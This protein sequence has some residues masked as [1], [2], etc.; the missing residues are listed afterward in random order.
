M[1]VATVPATLAAS[2][3]NL[4]TP[5]GELN[6]PAARDIFA[7]ITK[8]REGD[9]EAENMLAALTDI[10]LTG[11]GALPANGLIQ[12]KWL[13]EVYAA[14]AYNRRYI[15]LIATGDITA[16]TEM[17]FSVSTNSPEP[18]QAWAGNKAELPSSG[19]STA[20]ISSVFQKWGWAA[21]IA[22]EFFDIPGNE[23]F[24]AAFLRLVANSYKRVTDKWL[25]QQLVGASTLVAP[26]AY[27]TAGNPAY[28]AAV[29]MLI[30][31]IDTVSSDPIDGT[32]TFAVVNAAAW[33]QLIYSPKDALPEYINLNFGIQD[34]TGLA[35]KVQVVKGDIGIASTPAVL[36]G[37][38]DAAHYNELGGASPLNLDALDIARGGIDKSVIGYSQY[39]TDYA[40]ALV[41][42]GVADA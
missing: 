27:P 16:I 33:K 13:G 20:A 5:A 42:I 19:G 8:V 24:V 31:G 4:I 32:P 3:A 29:G 2:A 12:P 17:G 35:G 22:R 37:A 6:E 21:D 38:R 39:M 9:R 14:A 30:Q 26:D 18:V 41:K 11:A 25:L 36:V 23:Q 10:K 40:P 28:P 34:G 15:P 7:L 1:G